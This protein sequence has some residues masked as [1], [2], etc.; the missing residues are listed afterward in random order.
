MNHRTMNDQE[1]AQGLPMYDAPVATACV[2]CRHAIVNRGQCAQRCCALGC[3][4]PR[5]D[6]VN[7]PQGF[8]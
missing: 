5:N 6:A 8:H 3:T 4:Q 2:M 7:I 1:W